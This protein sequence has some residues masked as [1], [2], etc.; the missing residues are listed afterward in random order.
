[1]WRNFIAEPPY[2]RCI[3]VLLAEEPKRVTT[4][5][6]VCYEQPMAVADLAPW[7]CVWRLVWR[8]APE[9]RAPRRA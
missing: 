8:P 4:F 6:P 9:V 5:E 1:M 3:R 7:L 2:G